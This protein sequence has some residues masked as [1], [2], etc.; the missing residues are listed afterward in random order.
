[1]ATTIVW[2][3]CMF[4]MV[5]GTVTKGKMKIRSYIPIIGHA[6]LYQKLVA[7]NNFNVKIVDRQSKRRESK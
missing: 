3:K 5:N 7:Q 6:N 4:V 2:T 1:M